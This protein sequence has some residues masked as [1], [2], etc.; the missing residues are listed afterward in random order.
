MH[1]D[2][3]E[4]LRAHR[5]QLR[6]TAPARL[7]RKLMPQPW[8]D[9]PRAALAGACAAAAI[10]LSFVVGRSTAPTSSGAAQDVVASHV[11]SLMASHL[12]DVASTD[13]HTVKPW[14]EG[15][16]DFGPDVRDFAQEGFPLEGGRLDYV[17][18]RPA[19]ALVY[20]HGAHVIN[21]L[22]W[23][24]DGSSSTPPTLST[25]RGFQ[26]FSWRRNG[27]S[28]WAVSDLNAADLQKFAQLWQ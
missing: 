12:Q 8:L 5:D 6:Y 28:Y 3:S 11:R 9:R 26:L 15:R 2:L 18:S 20:R 1:D 24:A 22:E 16:L 14:F 4:L 23:P 21:V 10:L 13:Q 25:L 17:D 7:R 19:A 27:L